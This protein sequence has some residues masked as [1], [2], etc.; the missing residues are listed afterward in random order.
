M[1]TEEKLLGTEIKQLLSS[2]SDHGALHLTEIETD[3]VQTT[4]LL[5]EA[6]EKLGASFMAIHAAI[7]AQQAVVDGLFAASIAPSPEV[8][9]QLKAVQAEI[10][11][12]VNS[13]VT[14]LQ[15]QDM[16]NQLIERTLRR[17]TGLREVIVS[18]GTSSATIAP[19]SDIEQ[20]TDV[21]DS[22]NKML[23]AQSTK[24]ESV[25][26]KAVTQT[27]MDGGDIEL[28]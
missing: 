28:F 17:V 5:R 14:G 13:A 2:L 24:L 3:L 11:Q 8:T 9:E 16:T 20:I 18:V 21:V 10:G 19:E 12:H 27:H 22:V 26:W 1:T 6:I 25:L 7:S 15:F 23:E 4:F